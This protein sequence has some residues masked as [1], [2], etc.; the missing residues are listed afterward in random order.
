MSQTTPLEQRPLPLISEP[1]FHRP[2]SP[3]EMSLVT[4][5]D[6]GPAPDDAFDIG[7]GWVLSFFSAAKKDG[8]FALWGWVK[9]DFAID[10]RWASSESKAWFCATLTFLPL[11]MS[12]G[13]FEYTGDAVIAATII[14]R[15][16]DLS[17][18]SRDA[19]R[20]RAP[21]LRALMSERFDDIAA[22]APFRIWRA[23]PD[24]DQSEEKAQ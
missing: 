10:E 5:P 16:I 15:N 14:A 7:K 24:C 20:A 6:A 13:Y 2:V 11:G 8:R 19:L 21:E 4:N 12:F 23:N 9:G 22:D 18:L 17:D 1:P 3:D